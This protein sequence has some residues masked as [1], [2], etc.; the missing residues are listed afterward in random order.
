MRQARLLALLILLAVMAL[1]PLAG[2]ASAS[3][4]APSNIVPVRYVAIKAGDAV[5]GWEGLDARGEAGNLEYAA[6][7]VQEFGGEIVLKFRLVEAFVFEG[8][9]VLAAKLRALGYVVY[10]DP[11]VE[12]DEPLE[13]NTGITPDLAA[14]VPTIGADLLHSLGV[15]GEGVRVAI[16]DTGVENLHPW[17]VRNGESVVTWEYDA[18]GEGVVDYCR[19]PTTGE[20]SIHGTHVAGI[21]ASQD[22][23][24]RGVAPGADIY[25]II[26]F[27]PSTG[28]NWTYGSLIAAGIE[29]ALLGPDGLEN[30]G[31]EAHVINLSLG[32]M[33]S[34]FLNELLYRG[35]LRSIVSLMVEEAVSKGVIVVFSAGNSGPTFYTVNYNCSYQGVLCVAASDTAGTVSRADDTIAP[36]SSKGPLG[37]W[38]PAPHIAAP[39]VAIVAP[40]PTE[41][42]FEAAALSGTSMAA[43]HVAG[44]AALLLSAGKDPKDTPALLAN[45]ADPIDDYIYSLYFGASTVYYSSGSGLIDVVDAYNTP[46][47]ASIVEGPGFFGETVVSPS[48]P[49]VLVVEL[50][51]IGSQTATVT[52]SGMD[53]QYG[54]QPLYETARMFSD[55]ASPSQVELA[56]G[57]SQLVSIVV[58]YA[59]APPGPHSGV[60]KF[61]VTSGINYYRL[62]IPITVVSAIEV[63]WLPTD[64]DRTPEFLIDFIYTWDYILPVPV[65]VENVGASFAVN[66]SSTEPVSIAIVTPSSTVS[67]SIIW[68]DSLLWAPEPG[69]YAVAVTRVPLTLQ[70]LYPP[71]YTGQISISLEGLRVDFS[72]IE[73]QILLLDSRVGLLEA[74]TIDLEARVSGLERSAEDLSSVVEDLGRSVE[75]LGQRVGDLEDVV[76][77]LEN[78]VEL[79]ESSLQD[80]NSSVSQL[81]RA[82]EDLEYAVSSLEE[83]VSL[84]ESAVEDYGDRIGQLE[85]S[86]T[87]LQLELEEVGE[88]L[89]SLEASLV[90]VQNTLEKVDKSLGEAVEA[91]NTLEDRVGVL[92]DSASQAERDIGVLRDEISSLRNTVSLTSQTI[93]SISGSIQDLQYRVENASS[94]LESLE[95]IIGELS[96]RVSGLEEDSSKAQEALEASSNDLQQAKSEIESLKERISQLE[97]QL[98]EAKSSAESGSQMGMAGLAVG[99]LALLAVIAI[100]ART[101]LA[102][103]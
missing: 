70:W 17:L 102:R 82:V 79:L 65:I 100:A 49:G 8:S 99:G 45:T 96:A 14:S 66:V 34:P 68:S 32:A 18:T 23:T 59:G 22:S 43:P 4:S 11:V 73:E 35:V 78:R 33:R 41:T 36:F 75:S 87:S 98:E 42:G 39:G 26:V 47:V 50:K 56:P 67:Q 57:E 77:D 72:D 40:I 74:I 94:R 6:R 55:S 81:S 95:A 13:F 25:D 90:E 86:V 28:C 64:P 48:N 83:R 76:G 93:A 91:L 69:L 1:Q 46:V 103:E 54:P 52:Y 7:L 5:S 38:H 63:G 30:S 61:T 12:L 89:D 84:L 21:V 27:P 16:L 97:S 15:T 51:N 92:E 44:A 31:D 62:A 3:Q 9:P 29:A 2:V 20:P 19:D 85:D 37:L 80:L 71:S 60:V 24:F 53:L 88:R 58:E 101:M 10:P